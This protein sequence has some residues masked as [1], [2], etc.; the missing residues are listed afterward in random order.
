MA[1]ST[2]SFALLLHPE[3]KDTEALRKGMGNGVFASYTTPTLE[4][5]VYPKISPIPLLSIFQRF[6]IF[7]PS[8]QQEF[9]L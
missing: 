2:H 4:S 5:L 6:S 1:H 9:P 7:D 3:N 8:N